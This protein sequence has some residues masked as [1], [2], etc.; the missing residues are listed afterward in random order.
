MLR[1]LNHSINPGT[2]PRAASELGLET[3]PTVLMMGIQ[4][5]FLVACG[6]PDRA[7][8]DAGFKS[9]F[10]HGSFHPFTR[11]LVELRFANNTA[12]PHPALSH[13]KLRL[14]QYNHLPGG[15]E[16]RYCGGQNQGHG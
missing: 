7:F 5:E 15:T 6:P 4:E 14:D 12:L 2:I 3:M 10:P 9:E 8:Q 13:F 11:G 16:Q 1:L